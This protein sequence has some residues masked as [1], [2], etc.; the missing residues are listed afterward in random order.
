MPFRRLAGAVLAC[1]VLASLPAGAEERSAVPD[2]Y[3]WDLR[4][5]YPSDA[6]WTKAKAG[7]E[8]RIPSL[9]AFKGHLGDSPDALYR[10]LAHQMDL[11]RD[12]ARLYTYASQQSDQD[13]RIA[14]NLAMRESADQLNVTYASAASFIRPELLALGADKVRSFIASEP[15]L[16]P[17]R[18]YLEDILRRAPHTLTDAEEAIVA[19]AGRLTGAGGTVRE[20][21]KNAEMPYP[22]ITLSDGKA[23]RLDDAAY[24]QYRALASRTDRESVF[25]AFWNSHRE[26]QATLGAALN[27]QVQAHIFT[28]DVRKFGSCL[29][30]ATF[31]GNI[32]PRVYTQLIADVR[33]NLPTLH[34]Y[35]KLRQR[36]MG[37][38]ELRYSDLYAPIVSSVDRK[39]TP[40]EAME[41]T[42][43]AVAPL[44]KAYVDTLKI[45]FT[46]GWVDWMPNTG[47]ASGA[48][49][50]GAYDV[51]PYQLQNFT[52]LYEEVGTLAHESGHSMHTF[53]ADQHQP[54]VTHD[55]ATFVAEVASTLNENLLF[56]SQLDRTQDKP[57]RLFLLGS[58]LDNLR[59]TLFRQALF[60]DYELKIHQMAEK[61]E[62]LTGEV[63]TKLY[64]DM[65]REYYGHARGVC[66]VDP[67][68]G[69]E[70]AYIDHFFYNF[71]VYQY[72]TSIVASTAL[73]NGIRDEMKLSPPSTKKR[74]L[75]LA[76]LS[77]G[78]S[79]YPI[80][81]LKDAGVDMTT[82]AP[83][84]AAIREMNAVM[85]E[86]EK[87]LR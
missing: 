87:L 11:D 34:R 67:V 37:L 40:E 70:W 81:L 83:F 63:L 54:Y 15:R 9:G 16:Q 80:D 66:R 53:L 1:A 82:S 18:P 28:R 65:V 57:M 50:T 84:R 56:H 79:K 8:K 71:Y 75:Y 22:T 5:L 27:A 41:M 74:D 43:T 14:K 20:V 58:Y 23:V 68:I 86:I 77:S 49:S 25:T 64:L 47:K 12:L 30:A 73:A 26:Y 31:G 76:M 45:S 61:G 6:A 4:D 62:T 17:Y 35:L 78:S 33:A 38:K 7:L 48:Y 46:S 36:M 10:A 69:Y 51:H 52:G 32:P 59:G 85:D 60:A 55:Y 21:F 39:Y 42:L 2:R 72:A 13:A 29:E 19:K 3:K 44:G 24:T